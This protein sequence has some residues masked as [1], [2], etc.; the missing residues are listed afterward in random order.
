MEEAIAAAITAMNEPKTC[1]TTVLRRFLVDSNKDVS[2]SR[3]G[4]TQD[5]EIWNLFLTLHLEQFLEPVYQTELVCGLHD[6]C[7]ITMQMVLKL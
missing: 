7:T 6:C 1:S 2:E 3:T 5:L 4:K